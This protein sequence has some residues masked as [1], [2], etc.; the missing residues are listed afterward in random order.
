MTA[1]K[2]KQSDNRKK[3][4]DGSGRR[5]S[6]RKNGERCL[7]ERQYLRT[8]IFFVALFFAF[9]LTG[10]LLSLI[11]RDRLALDMGMMVGISI[12]AVVCSPPA[13][14]SFVCRAFYMRKFEGSRSRSADAVGFRRGRFFILGSL[15]VNEGGREYVSPSF[16]TR[17]EA[18]RLIGK[19]V[20]VFTS[21]GAAFVV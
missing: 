17:R 12:G 5:A 21:D 3:R 14:Y 2:K 13:A 7:F 19:K 11:M 20:S 10:A 8:G 16:F 9:T 1:L 4:A 18:E 6:K 15:V